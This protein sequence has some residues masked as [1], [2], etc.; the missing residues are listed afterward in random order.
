MS[1]KDSPALQVISIGQGI[2]QKFLHYIVLRSSI[3][4]VVV[5]HAVALQERTSCHLRRVS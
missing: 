2:V 4:R 3:V 1:F 5:D